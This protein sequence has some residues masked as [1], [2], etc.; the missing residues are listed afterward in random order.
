MKAFSG[1]SG[2][3]RLLVLTWHNVDGTWSSPSSRGA[4]RRGLKQQLKTLRRLATVVPLDTAL[5][6]LAEG[7]PL[8][9]RAAAITFDD[10]YRDT[11]TEATVLLNELNLPATVF[12]VPG[13]LSREVLPW[14]EQLAWAFSQASTTEFEWNGRRFVLQGPGERTRLCNTVCEELKRLD[15]QK[16]EK[17]VLQLVNLMAPRGSHRIEDMFLDWDG[18][19]EMI[20]RG[21]SVGSHSMYH[22]ILANESADAQQADL[23]ESKRLLESELQVP[24]DLFCYPNGKR[25]DYASETVA[26]LPTAGYRYAVTTETG[27][28]RCSTP[29]YEIR[30][31]IMQPERGAPGLAIIARDL[32]RD[33][34][35][36][37]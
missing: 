28:N 20:G 8:P 10:G 7:R 1:R 19:R 22:A 9:P 31:S 2:G 21:I 25:S 12:L 3:D 4:G 26:A 18:A 6:D 33:M 34:V 11:L 15:R 32:V 36:A 24:I 17:A 5:R 13:F 14:W 35:R 16:R 37:A 29:P 23:Q 27:W 30:R